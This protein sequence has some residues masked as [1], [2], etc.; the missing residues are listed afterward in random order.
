MYSKY[1]LFGCTKADYSCVLKYTQLCAAVKLYLIENPTPEDC[2]TFRNDIVTLDRQSD[3]V[4]VFGL[5]YS[6]F[7]VLEF[8]NWTSNISPESSCGSVHH[9]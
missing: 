6:D 7:L 5:M 8:R 3:I 4:I 2:L 1:T 9:L